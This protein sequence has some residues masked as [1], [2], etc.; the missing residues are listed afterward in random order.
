MTAAK[1][2]AAV[3]MSTHQDIVLVEP[4]VD[5]SVGPV[6][7]GVRRVGQTAVCQAVEGYVLND[8]LTNP[9]SEIETAFWRLVIDTAQRE[10]AEILMAAA[11]TFAAANSAT[12]GT[13]KVIRV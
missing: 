11:F 12:A 1:Q 3:V 13:P 7:K 4:F 2:P 8:S 5:L 10:V 6:V 9:T